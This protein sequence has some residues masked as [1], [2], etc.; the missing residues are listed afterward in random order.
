MLARNVWGAEADNY[1][2]KGWVFVNGV[3]AEMGMKVHEN[4]NIELHG[5]ARKNMDEK[6]NILLHKPYSFISQAEGI[7]LDGDAL[8]RIC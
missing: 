8:R 3:K 6:L 7:L 4:D 2:K 5:S 1:I